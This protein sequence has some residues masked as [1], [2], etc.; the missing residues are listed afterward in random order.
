M[1]KKIG[2]ICLYSVKELSSSLGVAELTIRSYLR[3]GRLKGKKLGVQW[4]VIEDSLR[5][6]FLNDSPEEAARPYRKPKAIT[7]RVKQPAATMPNEAPS[8]RDII[9][10]LN[11]SQSS[12]HSEQPSHLKT[13]FT[14]GRA[15]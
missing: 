1:P 7:S 4:Y 10:R 8:L 3:N 2:N 6:Y 14:K 13:L 15:T 12:E 5:D 11:I 9:D